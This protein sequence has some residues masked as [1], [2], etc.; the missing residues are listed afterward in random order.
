MRGLEKKKLLHGSEIIE[1]SSEE[2]FLKYKSV[3][4][5]YC[6]KYN[7]LNTDLE[8]RFQIASL[9]FVKAFNSYNNL[10]VPFIAYL[11]LVV[12]ND[13]LMEFRKSASSLFFS[14]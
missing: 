8:E 14:S 6:K 4:Y 7:N 2:A 12:N 11:Q 13:F 1:L 3:L 9:G 5:N 10:E